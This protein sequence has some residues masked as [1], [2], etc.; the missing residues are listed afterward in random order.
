MGFWTHFSRQR[1]GVGVR[2]GEGEQ[3]IE[4]DRRI[5]RKRIT[6]LEKELKEVITSRQQQ[7]KKRKTQCFLP[8]LLVTRTLENHP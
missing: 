4:L 2:G 3:Q 6:T 5:I 1:G 7:G 8:P